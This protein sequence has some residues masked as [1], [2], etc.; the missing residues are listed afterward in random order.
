[1][2]PVFGANFLSRRL[3]KQLDVS[4]GWQDLELDKFMEHFSYVRRNPVEWQFCCDEPSWGNFGGMCI[5]R[6]L[7]DEQ[8]RK[9]SGEERAF[10][11]QHFTEGPPKIRV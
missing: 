1:M 9:G 2:D 8:E 3:R 7:G 10:L 5:I 6:I 11:G 4:T